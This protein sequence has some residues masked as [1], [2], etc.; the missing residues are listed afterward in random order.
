MN[1]QDF[2]LIDALKIWRI[3]KTTETYGHAHLV[4]IGPSIIMTDSITDR[5]I[6]RKFGAAHMASKAT[7]AKK[8]RSLHNNKKN[9]YKYFPHI[10]V[11]MFTGKMT[12]KQ[13]L[14]YSKIIQF[15]APVNP[16]K[17]PRFAC[18]IDYKGTN[19]VSEKRHTEDQLG[20]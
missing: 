14:F 2:A 12:L 17:V 11:C 16:T 3:A 7:T 9:D 1:D 10:C 19:L 6:H 20:I 18:W 15:N 13:I 4:N 5:V 8:A